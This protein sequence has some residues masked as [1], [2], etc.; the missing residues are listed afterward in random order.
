DEINNPVQILIGTENT[1]EPLKDCSIVKTEYK[2]ANAIGTIGIIAPT[3]MDYAKAVS[4][5]NGITKNIN[6]IIKGLSP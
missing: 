1:V 2:I 3:R 5:L 6:D 4:V